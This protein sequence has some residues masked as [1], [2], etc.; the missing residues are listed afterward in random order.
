MELTL[1][2]GRALNKV[3]KNPSDDDIIKDD[4]YEYYSNS[5]ADMVRVWKI[6][7]KRTLE[8][9]VES[10]VDQTGHLAEDISLSRL[11][12]EMWISQPEKIDQILHRYTKVQCEQS[13][14]P[15]EFL[16]SIEGW[17]TSWPDLVQIVETRPPHEKFDI[18]LLEASYQ[19]KDD[20]P[21]PKSKLGISLEL[22]FSSSSPDK[23][24]FATCSPWSCTSQFYQR[25]KLEASAHYEECHSLGLGKVEPPFESK[26]WAEK[27]VQLTKRRLQALDSGD[28]TKMIA[29]DVSTRDYL[30]NLKVMQ[31]I[32]IGPESIQS[33][34]ELWYD[35]KGT[36]RR[37]AVLLWSFSQASGEYVG[38]TTWKRL[39][40]PPRR[41]DVNSPALAAAD[42]S[43]P[44]FNMDSVMDVTVNETLFN[45]RADSMIPTIPEN[46]HSPNASEEKNMTHYLA[47]QLPH[48]SR[49]IDNSY[50]RFPYVENV[51]LGFQ[52]ILDL[53][54]NV[55]YPPESSLHDSCQPL[56]PAHPILSSN[57]FEA[58]EEWSNEQLPGN[59]HGFPEQQTHHMAHPPVHEEYDRRQSLLNFDMNTHALLQSQLEA[60]HPDVSSGVLEL[61]PQPT[62][63]QHTPTDQPQE[64][65][66]T[67]DHANTA[68]INGPAFDTNT[69]IYL[70]SDHPQDS[71]CERNAESAH[72]IDQPEI[73]VPLASRPTLHHHHSFA[74]LPRY[75][76]ETHTSLSSASRNE[77]ALLLEGFDS[78]HRDT[79]AHALPPVPHAVHG[80][81]MIRPHSQPPPLNTAV[82]ESTVNDVGQLHPMSQSLSKNDWL[83]VKLEG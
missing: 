38:V 15:P 76:T 56:F 43:L 24:F 2:I 4:E 11:Y 82:E 34:R 58:Q 57:Y 12:F 13:T 10:E 9:D 77:L 83:E 31:Q 37:M 62:L 70:Q 17:R 40:P 21:P 68:S 30:H 14:V 78:S 61:Q 44:P 47:T 3:S 60:S 63:Y 5:I 49:I 66:P 29:A 16:E 6:L 45:L 59:N 53:E 27:F 23:N 55:Q 75:E 69:H 74:G 32:S 1:R 35:H 7:N 48:D 39:I 41:K 51:P 28:D 73:V 20:F 79:Q 19:L 42:M 81:G 65:K 18:I 50:H 52:H 26:W 25:G 80:L 46:R 64:I 22:E 36:Q 8:S 72:H 71:D 54:H 33:P 67:D